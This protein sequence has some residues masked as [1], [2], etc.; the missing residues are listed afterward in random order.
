MLSCAGGAAGGGYAQVIPMEEVRQW[1]RQ[2][3]PVPLGGVGRPR[4]LTQHLVSG[5]GLP[6]ESGWSLPTA[7]WTLP[8]PCACCATQ[9]DCRVGVQK[10][11]TDTVHVY[12]ILAIFHMLPE[13]KARC[14][15]ITYKTKSWLLLF[16]PFISTSIAKK[17]EKALL[18]WRSRADGLRKFLFQM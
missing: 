1:G 16:F 12:N 8:L 9:R 10:H 6:G 13:K 11:R 15:H 7:T 3:V 5:N 2:Q 17:N 18:F 14:P 4:C